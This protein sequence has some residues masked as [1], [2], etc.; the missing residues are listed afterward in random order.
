MS[1]ADIVERIAHESGKAGGNV[2]KVT[3]NDEAKN[4]AKNGEVGGGSSKF[5]E[6]IAFPFLH[7]RIEQN[8]AL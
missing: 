5:Q 4:M 1:P 7:A 6:A 3:T 8:A 2:K